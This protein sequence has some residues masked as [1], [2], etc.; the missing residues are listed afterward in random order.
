METTGLSSELVAEKLLHEGG[1]RKVS[2]TGLF[3]LPVMQYFDI[4]GD[5]VVRLIT[6]SKTAVMDEFIS[7]NP[8]KLSIGALT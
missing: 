1:R 4:C 5:C 3:A 6:R 8:Q 2:K 7:E